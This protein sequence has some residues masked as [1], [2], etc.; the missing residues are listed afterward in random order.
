[1]KFNDLIFL[2]ESRYNKVAK[3]VL[4]RVPPPIYGIRAE[5]CRHEYDRYGPDLYTEDEIEQLV[6]KNDDIPFEYFD[7]N[8]ENLPRNIDDFIDRIITG[9]IIRCGLEEEEYLFCI[10]KNKLLKYVTDWEN[11]LGLNLNDN[12]GD[13]P[14]DDDLPQSH[15]NENRFSKAAQKAL[16]LEKIKIKKAQEYVELADKFFY[17]LEQLRKLSLDRELEAHYQN[18]YDQYRDNGRTLMY[19]RDK[20]R[21]F[22]KNVESLN[23]QLSNKANKIFI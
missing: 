9:E 17:D 13:D 18:L 16:E 11:E 5:M 4:D 14:E 22:L 8:S 3:K 10:D 7:E 2:V 1:M 19:F 23:N 12:E 21:I 15:V 20:D 6:Y